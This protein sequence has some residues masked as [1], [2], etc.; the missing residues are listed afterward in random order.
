[1]NKNDKKKQCDE[2]YRQYRKGK[3]LSQIVFE[4]IGNLCYYTGI[5]LG[6]ILLICMFIAT[7]IQ[8]LNIFKM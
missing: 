1:M 7:I 6:I 4:L 3:K 8:Q 2:A 5:V